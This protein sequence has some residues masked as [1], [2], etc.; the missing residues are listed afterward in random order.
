MTKMSFFWYTVVKL[1]NL[2]NFG[3]E[4][5]IVYKNKDF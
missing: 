4:N 5:N 2:G 3:K 1:P